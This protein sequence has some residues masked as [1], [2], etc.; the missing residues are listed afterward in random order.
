MNDCV[1][2]FIV[3]CFYTTWDLI[4]AMLYLYS[5]VFILG[6]CCWEL[7]LNAFGLLCWLVMMLRYVS[8]L[9]VRYDFTLC[10]G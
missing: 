2:V 10:F 8:F 7:L 6:G 4:C 5:I 1:T 3:V 9:F